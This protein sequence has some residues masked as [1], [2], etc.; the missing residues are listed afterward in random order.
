M[1]SDNTNK[2]QSVNLSQIA[3]AAGVSKMTVSRVLR[4]ASGFS[5][6]TRDKVMR[7]VER[8]G[9]LPN[10]IAA[11][12]GAAQASTLIGV[13]VPSL[14]DPLV[15]QA[16]EALDRNFERF[17]YQMI[18]GSHNNQKKQEE[19]WLKNLLEW[20]PAAV[21]L[22]NKYHSK[23]TV[24]VL[25]ESAIPVLEFWNLNT[26]PI[27]MSVGFNEYDSGYQMSQHAI[28]NGYTKA[29]VLLASTDDK[30][31]TPERVEAFKKG[32]NE[33]G[34]SVVH[35][36]ILNDK[37]CFYAGFYGTENLLNH[38]PNTDMIYYMNDAMAIGGL[39]WCRRKGLRIPADIGI[40]GWGGH[41]AASILPERLTT[42]TIPVLQI[43]KLAAEQLAR[44]LSGEDIQ[45]VTAVPAKLID[46]D[47]L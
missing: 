25:R 8:Y 12:F 16:L 15:M 11:S 44:A 20:R 42:T 31:V 45:N 9:Y 22:S 40:V 34:G 21:M 4:N 37:P 13:C 6:A 30:A 14:S 10:R 36:E 3:E 23:N 2:K 29:S 26:S 35:T 46:G 24:R 33:T 7:E 32:F 41:E 1:S 5:E 27:T 18:I 38:S 28:L 43:G 19:A 47:T 17:G 39:A